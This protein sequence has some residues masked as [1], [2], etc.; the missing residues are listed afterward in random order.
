MGAPE[1]QTKS[2]RT[3]GVVEY[4]PSKLRALSLMPLLTKRGEGW[5]GVH[6]CIKNEDKIFAK[7]I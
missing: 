4:L 3:E 5:V 6:R 7:D 1:K 2:K